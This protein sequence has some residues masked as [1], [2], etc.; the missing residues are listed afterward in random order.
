MND[1]TTEPVKQSSVI[2][3]LLEVLWAPAVVFDRTRARK[4]GMYLLILAVIGTVIVVSTGSLARPFLDAN[5]DL[6][7]A[8]SAKAG[9]PI[10]EAAAEVT[11]KITVYVYYAAPLLFIPIG[12]FLA[13][14]FVMW[15]GKTLSAP[16]RYGQA[17][18]IA[19]ISST[20]R[21]FG[22]LAT[23]VQGAVMD[24]SNVRS[25]GDSSI[26]PARFFDPYTMS[27]LLYTFLMTID[28][29]AVWQYALIA[30]GVSVVAR[31]D[32]STG[33]LVAL[34]SWALS[35]ALTLIPGLLAS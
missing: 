32:R 11:R 1:A 6:Q 31:V 27:N 20:P 24:T 21:I 28:L 23:A 29:F 13:A 4:A 5:A 17:L 9:K 16:L 10:P 19:A 18:L 34:M 26:G 35:S 8:L 25:L 2:E 3:D 7:M 33:A 14:L 15:A 30:I 22:Y 12:G